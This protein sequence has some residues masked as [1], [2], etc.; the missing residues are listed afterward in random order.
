[1]SLC[2]VGKNHEFQPTYEALLLRDSSRR[3]RWY[4]ERMMTMELG[5]R[6]DRIME[7]LGSERCHRGVPMEVHRLVDEMRSINRTGLSDWQL[8][9]LEQMIT[10]LDR[11]VEWMSLRYLEVPKSDPLSEDEQAQEKW[12]REARERLVGE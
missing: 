10:Q 11:A 1:M 6:F 7:V 8:P 12:A 3:E 2:V 5:A 9:I 4:G